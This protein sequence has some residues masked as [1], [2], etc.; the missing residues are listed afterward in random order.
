MLLKFDANNIFGEDQLDRTFYD[1]LKPLIKLWIA[2]IREDISWDDLVRA[3]NKAEPKVRI[4]EKTHLDQ[5]FPK[6]KQPLKMSLNSRDNQAKKPRAQPRQ[7]RQTPLNLTN[8]RPQIR[9][10]KI[11]KKSSRKKSE[12]E[13]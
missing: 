6:R 1:G 8:Q 2:N 5:Q 10:R 4:Q 3:A 12:K 9:S 7:L 13:K 11:G